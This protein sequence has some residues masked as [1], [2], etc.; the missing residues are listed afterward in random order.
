MKTDEY[1]PSKSNKQKHVE[2]CLAFC[3]ACD[4][5]SRIRIRIR[6]KMSRIHNTG[7]KIRIRF[8]NGNTKSYI[9]KSKKYIRIFGSNI[10]CQTLRLLHLKRF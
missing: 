10:L 6:T 4:E 2:F 3:Q 7:F 5:Y 1:V 8:F 9:Q